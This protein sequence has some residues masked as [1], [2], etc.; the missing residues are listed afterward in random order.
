MT[1]AN[2]VLL[3]G[4]AGFL[5]IKISDMV[6]FNALLS[7]MYNTGNSDKLKRFLYS[8]AIVGMNNT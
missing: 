1:A 2:K 8:K 5:T 3:S 6:E 4:G 7:E